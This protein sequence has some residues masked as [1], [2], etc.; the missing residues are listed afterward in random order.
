MTAEEVVLAINVLQKKLKAI[1]GVMNCAAD[2]DAY[3]ELQSMYQ[4]E[5]LALLVSIASLNRTLARLREL[6][7]ADLPYM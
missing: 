1:D 2:Y 4:G 5:R 7:E 3:C 6:D